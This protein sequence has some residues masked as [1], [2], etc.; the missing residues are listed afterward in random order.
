MEIDN[1]RTT[2]MH[3]PAERSSNPARPSRRS[4]RPWR[5][6]AIA[7]LIAGSLAA[8]ALATTSALTLGSTANATLGKPVMINP[9]GHTLY[10]LSPETSRHLLCKSAECFKV[11]PPVTVKSSKVKLKT[12]SGVQGHLGIVRRSNGTLQVT[13]RGEPLYRFSGDSG[14][15]QDHGQGIESFGGKWHAVTASSSEA[16]SAPTT[17]PSM[18]PE[19]PSYTAPSYPASTPA[20]PSPQPSPPTTTSTP[21]TTPAP[22][23]P[24]YE[25]PTY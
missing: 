1:G 14:K 21:A 6:I 15:D 25:Y 17:P 22:T 23:P 9:Q 18:Q 5:L 2:Q 8:T 7:V 20:A 19:T 13:L 10:A 11:W 3:S 16:T 12:G 24:P 4:L